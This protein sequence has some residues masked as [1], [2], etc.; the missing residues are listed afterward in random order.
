MDSFQVIRPQFKMRVFRHCLEFVILIEIRP[1]LDHILCRFREEV[2][3]RYRQVAPHTVI[4]IEWALAPR[5]FVSSCPGPK[6]E[7][8]D[9]KIPDIPIR[10]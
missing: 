10:S 8:V 6:Q 1:N 4:R 7:I 5:L 3:L 9:K 2:P